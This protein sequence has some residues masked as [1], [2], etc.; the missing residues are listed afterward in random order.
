MGFRPLLRAWVA[1]RGAGLQR[2]EGRK[3]RGGNGRSGEKAR[4]G[5][6]GHW[7]SVGGGWGWD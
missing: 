4:N 2:G 5:G 3:G 6:T 1:K 7:P